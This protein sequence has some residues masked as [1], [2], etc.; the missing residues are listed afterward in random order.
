MTEGGVAHVSATDWHDR[1][2]LWLPI[3]ARP[4]NGDGLSRVIVDRQ[5]RSQLP[6]CFWAIDGG[7]ELT[8]QS[9]E[10][11]FVAFVGDVFVLFRIGLVIEEFPF[12]C[13]DV[14]RSSHST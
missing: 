2:L 5:T 3:R 10:E 7:P 6:R 13:F 12:D 4:V 8:A 1:D 9:G 14:A 11:L